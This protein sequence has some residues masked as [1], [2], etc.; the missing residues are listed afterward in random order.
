MNSKETLDRL[1]NH[2]KA[3]TVR[4]PSAKIYLQIESNIFSK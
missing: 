3:E 4:P 1:V 2:N